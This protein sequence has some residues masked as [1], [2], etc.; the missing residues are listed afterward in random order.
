AVTVKRA[1]SRATEKSNGA[2][3][4]QDLIPT[5]RDE[6]VPLWEQNAKL[7]ICGSRAIGEGVKAEVVKMI[8]NNKKEAGTETTEQSAKEWWEGLR[9]VRYA[10]DVFD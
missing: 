3:Y 6:V 4:V 8:L 5:Y 10:T 2:K 1:Y 9:N 7:Y